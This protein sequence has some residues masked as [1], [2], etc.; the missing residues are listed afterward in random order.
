MNTI[1]ESLVSC[2]QTGGEGIVKAFWLMKI[3]DVYFYQVSQ[4]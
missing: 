4:F 3:A 1:T 2:Q